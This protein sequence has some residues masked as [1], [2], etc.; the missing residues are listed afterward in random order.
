[1]DTKIPDISEKGWLGAPANLRTLK[2][3]FR[4]AVTRYLGVYS[5]GDTIFLAQTKTDNCFP[6]RR[7]SV[8]LHWILF[9]IYSV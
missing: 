9:L 4:G 5:S 2:T 3:A 1:M 8:T 6:K 7:L